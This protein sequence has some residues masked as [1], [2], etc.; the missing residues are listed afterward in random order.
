MATQR[1]VLGTQM[2]GNQPRA[3]S[4]DRW[5]YL[6]AGLAIVA[7]ALLLRIYHLGYQEFWVDEA[8]SDYWAR[9][10]PLDLRKSTPVYLVLLRGWMAIAGESEAALRFPSAAFGT[11][12]VAATVWVG[13][14]WF[15]PRVG[16]WAGL[17][18]AASPIHIY[19]SQ[20][21][22]AYALVTLAL[23]V[24]Y[25]LLWRALERGSGRS[26]ALFSLFALL[27]VETHYLAILGLIA[28]SLWV[29]AWP[30]K[31]HRRRRCIA[32][33]AAMLP[34]VLLFAAWYLI[35]I[36]GSGHEGSA[37]VVE[38]WQKTPPWLA[39][40]KTLEIFSLGS[41]QG[42]SPIILK[43]F[44]HIELPLPL[45]AAGIIS[46]SVVGLWAIVPRR[47]R[48]SKRTGF[49]E[50]TRLEAVLPLVFF[51]PLLM[52]WLTSF[53]KPVYV[54]GRYD[55]MAFPLWPLL[56]GVGFARMQQAGKVGSLLSVALALIVFC[57]VGFKLSLYYGAPPYWQKSNR[58][59][60]DALDRLVE[61]DGLVIFGGLRGVE[62][63]YYLRRLGY[64]WT[65]RRCVNQQTGRRFG[66]RIFPVDTEQSPAVYS[67]DR[68]LNSHDEL[69]KDLRDIMSQLEGQQA[70]PW[71]AFTHV[72]SSARGL[73][74]TRTEV[75]LLLELQRTGFVLLDV[76]RPLAELRIYTFRKVA[77]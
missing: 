73:R 30:K 2:P 44:N 21:A 34:S 42:L 45:R 56:L 8:A 61:N 43:Q 54:A 16:L 13:W 7:L 19:Y 35:R 53:V 15:A 27:T 10:S 64:E 48:T 38:A 52:M 23:L 50:V 1:T 60:A 40:P 12:F 22:R 11:L 74:L 41:H 76:P 77:D 49:G 17:I 57:V 28:A 14:K 62:T 31:E 59:S 5:K 9:T 32:Y 75:S 39:I 20:E 6:A 65:G 26:W 69:R 70:A 46:L 71:I 36:T 63:L 3:A 37:W 24:S 33:A 51:T 66:C 4:V 55:M 18:A 68:V 47:W 67:P 25:A 58:A 72:G 29:L